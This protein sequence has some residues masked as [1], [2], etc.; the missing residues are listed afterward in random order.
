MGDYLHILTLF[1]ILVSIAVLVLK[2]IE[3]KV[4]YPFNSGWYKVFYS[5]NASN[6]AEKSDFCSINSK[7]PQCILSS[8]SVVGKSCMTH[9]FNCY[10][11]K[12]LNQ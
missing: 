5:S 9:L 12:Q 7:Y 2:K 10:H 6:S 3:M 1:M 11:F 4:D 8:I